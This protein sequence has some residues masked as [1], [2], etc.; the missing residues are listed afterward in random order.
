MQS[1]VFTAFIAVCSILSVSA[2]TYPP[3][4]VSAIPEADRTQW[5]RAQT[6]ACPLLCGDQDKTAAQNK[7]YPDN[8]HFVCT[9]NDG[10]TP[11]LTEYSQTIPYFRCQ[12][13]VKGCSDACTGNSKCQSECAANR[14]CGA[15]DPQ[16]LNT[17]TITST[18]SASKTSSPTVFT[19]TDANGFVV[20]G[21]TAAGSSG[22]NSA[23]S[24]MLEAGSAYGLGFVAAGIAIGAAL[25]GV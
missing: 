12:A 8:L 3:L 20:T 10:T 22:S 19:T 24:L 2:Q 11:N 5:C 16:R 13:E 23:G 25:V 1:S 6:A 15:T 9:C 7:C 4:N 17:S 14:P 18:T 21:T